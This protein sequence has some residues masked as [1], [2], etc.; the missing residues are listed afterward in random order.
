[1]VVSV[2]GGRLDPKRIRREEELEN[3][4]TSTALILIGAL[5]FVLPIP[6]TFILGAL[7]VLAGLAARLFGL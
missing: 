4:R 5:V 3:M 6:G 1:M 2:G 7:I